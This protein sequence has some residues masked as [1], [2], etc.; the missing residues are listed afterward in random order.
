MGILGWL[1][2][3]SGCESNPIPLS[4]EN[5]RKEVTESDVPVVVDFYSDSCQ[6]CRVLV[7]TFRKLAR[8]YEGRVKI[9]QLNVEAGPRTA[10][11][12]AVRATPTVLFF[13]RG[14]VVE[15]A[16]GVR[17]PRYYEQVIENELLERAAQRPAAELN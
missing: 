3:E 6:P 9:A 13:K 10:F 17:A 16:I 15:R 12:L 1:G 14:K 8:K 5:F 11:G 4:D 7:P 2:L